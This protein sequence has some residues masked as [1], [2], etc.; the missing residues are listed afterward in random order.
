M[1]VELLT[2]R[3]A[4][5]IAGVLGCYDRILIFGT[6]PG[7]C[8]AGGMKSFLYARQIRIFD[9]PKFKVPFRERIRENAERTAKAAGIEIE[10]I[11]TRSIR[12]E[13]RSQE[14]LSKRPHALRC[15]VI[16]A[17]SQY[18]RAARSVRC[19]HICFSI[20]FDPDS[21]L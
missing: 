15:R 10:F 5:Q 6:L 13:D 11:R 19:G 9:Y 16:Y 12:E 2:E 18:K 7:I 20:V 21:A 8:Y 1:G 4:S 17:V 3:H 14:L